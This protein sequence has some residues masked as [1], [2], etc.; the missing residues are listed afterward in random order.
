MAK[1][2]KR[3]TTPKAAN[4]TGEKHES[5]APITASAVLAHIVWVLGAL[6]LALATAVWV[7]ITT[8]QPTSIGFFKDLNY[9]ATLAHGLS[10]LGVL[11]VGLHCV[12]HIYRRHA[13]DGERFPGTLGTLVIPPTLRWLRVL[14][15]VGIVVAPTGAYALFFVPRMFAAL[16]IVHN[17]GKETDADTKNGLALINDW[18]TTYRAGGRTVLRGW[19]W[20]SWNDGRKTYEKS[21]NS[22]GPDAWPGLQPALYTG[23][24]ASLI[25]SLGW[26]LW[27]PLQ[28]R[29]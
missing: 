26:L 17:G 5:A 23:L 28:P 24:A 10:M 22:T 3:R 19:H 12:V 2:S 8:F 11:L 20:H 18:G 4:S 15:F 1:P 29:A 14:L 21:S 9:S 7:G 27:R 16:S 13:T 6:A 25:V